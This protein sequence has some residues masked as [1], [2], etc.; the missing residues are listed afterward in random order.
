MRGSVVI[1]SP[2]WGFVNHS[3]N[4][5]FVENVAYG[6]Y[7]SSFA[8]EDGN[9]IGLMQANLSISADGSSDPIGARM[10]IHD[11]GFNGHGYWLQGPGV[12]MISNISAG[13]SGPGFL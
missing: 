1:G 4:V 5:E 2:G 3:S 9:E 10:D 11:F 6:V 12:K 8:S 7:G 13:S